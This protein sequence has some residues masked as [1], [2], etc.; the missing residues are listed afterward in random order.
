MS[1]PGYATVSKRSAVKVTGCWAPSPFLS[2][3]YMLEC[4]PTPQNFGT[5]LF[6][7]MSC[8]IGRH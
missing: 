5:T 1:T 6:C 7:C 3:P 4:E 8:E 2:V